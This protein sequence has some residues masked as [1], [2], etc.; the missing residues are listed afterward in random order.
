MPS[1]PTQRCRCAGTD[2]VVEQPAR[3]YHSHDLE[4]DLTDHQPHT[5]LGRDLAGVD[6][7]VAAGGTAVEAVP[8]DF[9]RAV[10]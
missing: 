9:S 5:Q 6:G 1:P 10:E 3:G 4:C 2:A 7:Q 8:E